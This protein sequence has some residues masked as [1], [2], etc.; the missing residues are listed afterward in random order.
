MA[1]AE[2]TVHRIKGCISENAINRLSRTSAS[3]S[4]RSCVAEDVKDSNPSA[5]N[6]IAIGGRVVSA[7]SADSSKSECAAVQP[8]HLPLISLELSKNPHIFLIGLSY[9]ER[10]RS[11]KSNPAKVQ[12]NSTYGFSD[13]VVSK[14]VMGVYVSKRAAMPKFKLI[15]P[16]V[17]EISWSESVIQ[18]CTSAATSKARA[19]IKSLNTNAVH[20]FAHTRRNPFSESIAQEIRGVGIRGSG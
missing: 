17:S 8:A 15:E 1:L 7:R 13:L 19:V 6:N 20:H 10:L 11:E 18:C 14:S 4:V 9:P 2:R 12:I 5:E 3:I 16:I